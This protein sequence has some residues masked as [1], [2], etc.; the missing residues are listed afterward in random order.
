[1]LFPNK[2]STVSH[3]LLFSELF[4]SACSNISQRLCSF[5]SLSLKSFVIRAVIK[6]K[7]V[8]ANVDINKFSSNAANVTYKNTAKIRAATIIGLL[9]SFSRTI[10]NIITAMGNAR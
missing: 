1:M 8:Y 5:S 2:S 10:E 6:D 9:S 7:T 4:A 3:T